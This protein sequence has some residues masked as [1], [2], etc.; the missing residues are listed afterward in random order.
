MYD[1]SRGIVIAKVGVGSDWLK[2]PIWK[3]ENPH[4]WQVFHCAS[5]PAIFI[6]WA[7]VTASPNVC[8]SC[9]RRKCQQHTPSTIDVPKISPASIVCRYARSANELVSSAETLV[10][11][12]SPFT[13]VYPTGCCIHELATRMKYPDSHVPAT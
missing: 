11:C 1:S 6:A 13:I 10:R 3:S 12:A 7:L 8:V 5:D 2:P 9:R 4:G